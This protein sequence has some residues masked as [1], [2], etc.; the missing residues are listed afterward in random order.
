MRLAAAFVACVIALGAASLRAQD[1][2][3]AA[4]A[5]QLLLA[6]GAGSDAAG[7]ITDLK[8]ECRSACNAY[9]NQLGSIDS[10][11]LGPFL[12][13]CEDKHAALDEYQKGVLYREGYHFSRLAAPRPPAVPAGS[14]QV[15]LFSSLACPECMADR[16]RF[17]EW[18]ASPWARSRNVVVTVQPLTWGVSPSMGIDYDAYAFV[19]I[20]SDDLPAALAT[21]VR[22]LAADSRGTMPLR[23]SEDARA[24][25][26]RAGVG[27][28]EVARFMGSFSVQS[29]LR[30]AQLET[31]QNRIT[32]PR[33]YVVNG[34]FVV[35]AIG[36]DG[37]AVSTSA[38]L[39]N[40]VQFLVQREA[41]QIGESQR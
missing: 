25:L 39:L 29:R 2:S 36:Q 5:R 8:A 26:L 22:T 35:P 37:S 9:L 13:N 15:I 16:D 12:R 28:A 38:S 6:C 3:G 23:G 30:K 4:R 20:V 21:R 24:L 40:V 18:S 34:K 17:M 11:L 41:G 27:Q 10:R 33:A 19:D 1:A 32:T 14:H 31:Q 7:P